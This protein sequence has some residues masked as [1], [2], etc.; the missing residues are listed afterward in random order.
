[1]CHPG[2][3]DLVG[4][5]NSG[6]EGVISDGSFA[7]LC[8]KAE[9]ASIQCITANIPWMN[10]LSVQADITIMV[11]A[12]FAPCNNY[13]DSTGLVG[14]DIDLIQVS[15]MTGSIAVRDRETRASAANP[16]LFEPVHRPDD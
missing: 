5:L 8:D 7:A 9:Y 6:L 4:E 1:M 16:S 3:P 10:Q 14:F 11:E 2:R 15:A 13:P 12:N